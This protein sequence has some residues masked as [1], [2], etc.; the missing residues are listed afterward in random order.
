MGKIEVNISK[1]Q[2][3]RK[4]KELASK[5]S[6]RVSRRHILG[7][8][9]VVGDVALVVIGIPCKCLPGPKVFVGTLLPIIILYWKSIE[10]RQ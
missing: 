6:H 1:L 5:T 4:I 8:V 3:E 2:E 9:V 7:R 10:I